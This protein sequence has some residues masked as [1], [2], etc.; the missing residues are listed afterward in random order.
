MA[1]WLVKS[2]AEV[3][4][5]GDLKRDRKTSWD[6]VRNY[7]AR[8]YLREFAVGEQVLFYHSNSDSSGIAGLAKVIRTA[9]PDLTQFDPKSEYFDPKATKSVPRWFSPDLQFERQFKTVIALSELKKI[10]ALQKMVLLQR[11]SRLSVQPVTA[12]EF[13]TI[14]KLA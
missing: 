2:E 11:G 3:Y 13:S 8:N 12:V 6:C 14:I 1:Y 5:I 9:H 4:S 10:T 7:Q